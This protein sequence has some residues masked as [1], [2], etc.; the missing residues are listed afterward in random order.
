MPFRPPLTKPE[1]KAMWDRNPDSA[2]V[3]ALVWEVKRLRGLVL[4][5]DQLQRVL[6][7]LGG[8]QGSILTGLRS[9]LKDEPCIIEFPRLE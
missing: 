4:R 1:L 7:E 6:G 8:A 3:K 5:A 2:D 9:E